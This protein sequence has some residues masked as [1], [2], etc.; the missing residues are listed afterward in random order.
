MR[1]IPDMGIGAGVRRRD[2]R[3]LAAGMEM[4]VEMRI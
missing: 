1:V 2:R 4:S 3:R